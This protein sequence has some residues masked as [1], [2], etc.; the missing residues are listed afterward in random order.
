MGFSGGRL[1]LH[2][3][4]VFL[5]TTKS[6]KR[7]N[8]LPQKKLSEQEKSKGK[9]H[10][11][12]GRKSVIKNVAGPSSSSSYVIRDALRSQLQEKGFFRRTIPYTRA[13]KRVGASRGWR[14]Y[15]AK[16]KSWVEGRE[17]G[18]KRNCFLNGRRRCHRCC[19][20][21]VGGGCGGEEGERKSKRMEF[22][23][24]KIH[25]SLFKTA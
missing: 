8:F 20:L 25:K 11:G 5:E 14:I 10:V 13:R 22:H 12:P 15:G 18:G 1:G 7:W 16:G 9:K 21:R 24:P 4:L 23:S 19:S 3:G 6:R 2:F 17:A